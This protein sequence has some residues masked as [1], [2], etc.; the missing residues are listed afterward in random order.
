MCVYCEGRVICESWNR[1]GGREGRKWVV[2][3]VN[4]LPKRRGQARSERVVKHKGDIGFSSA[5]G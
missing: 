3:L 1:R 2:R 4:R 5:Y